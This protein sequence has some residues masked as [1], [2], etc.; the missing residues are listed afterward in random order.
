MTSS[1]DRDL[2][3][4]LA[5][6]PSPEFTARVR[7]AI[8]REPAPVRFAPRLL[9]AGTIAAGAAVFVLAATMWP[10]DTASDPPHVPPAAPMATAIPAAREIPMLS[11]H[12]HRAAQR[13][14]PF[15]RPARETGPVS[16]APV[17][18]L[19]SPETIEAFQ[20]L[21]RRVN[22]QQLVLALD[23]PITDDAFE[24]PMPSV[25]FEPFEF[26]VPTEGVPQ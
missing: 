1:F 2:E 9:R 10:R 22:E 3:R 23:G 7:V 25:R 13:A 4:A 16:D 14:R 21:I 18:V 5:V 15:V 19:V 26:L 12:V 24:E 6:E 20:R 17:E 11:M 8:S